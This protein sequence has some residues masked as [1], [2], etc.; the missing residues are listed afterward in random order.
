VSAPR[1]VRRL[2]SAVRLVAE[3]INT[4][5]DNHPF[6]TDAQAHDFL[7]QLQSVAADA[8]ATVERETCNRIFP[9]RRGRP[10]QCTKRY[11]HEEACAGALLKRPEL[12]S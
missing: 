8:L 9:D 4:Y 5:F 11:A 12:V 10:V 1:Q 3:G 2:A 6:W 7:R